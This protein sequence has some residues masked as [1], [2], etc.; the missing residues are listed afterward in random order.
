MRTITRVGVESMVLRCPRS[1]AFLERIVSACERIAPLRLADSSWDNVGLI[2][3]SPLPLRKPAVL[4]TNDLTMAVV[5]EAVAKDASVIIAYHPPWFRAAKSINCTGQLGVISM[6]IA[7]GIS[8]YSPHTALDAF[9]G[10]SKF[11][12][13]RTD[14]FTLSAI[15]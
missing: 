5:E 15:S 14:R 12:S 2:A 13:R 6:C 8:I 7:H 1:K 4:V 10:G 9:K 11:V 3:E